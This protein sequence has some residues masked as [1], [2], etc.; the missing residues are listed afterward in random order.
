MAGRLRLGSG[1]VTSPARVRAVY[2]LFETAGA[3]IAGFGTQNS[4]TT[5]AAVIA[6]AEI[7]DSLGV[8]PVPIGILATG[9]YPENPQLPPYAAHRRDA[10]RDLCVEGLEHMIWDVDRAV[11]A[12]DGKVLALTQLDHAHPV[13]DRQ[14]IAYSLRNRLFSCIMYDCSHLPLR[15]NIRRTAAFVQRNKSRVLVQGIVDQ[16]Y[17]GGAERPQSAYTTPE[18]AAEYFR[19]VRPFL[20]VANLGTEHRVCIPGY[21]PRYRPSLARQITAALGRRML[22]LHGS[23]CLTRAQLHGLAGDGILQVNVWTR[24]EKEG[25]RALFRHVRASER[26]M[27]RRPALSHFTLTGVRDAWMSAVVPLI[28]EYMISFGYDELVRYKTELAGLRSR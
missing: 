23:S 15:E 10:G 22:V 4:W 19:R 13:L 7:A 21:R 5:Q 18:D 17:E 25:A 6:A 9:H 14:V 27:A 11:E 20:L 28:K 3:C 24:L 12:A 8:R 2:R 1:V 26:A 16:V